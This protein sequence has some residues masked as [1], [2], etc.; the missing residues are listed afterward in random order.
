MAVRRLPPG[1][2]AVITLEQTKGGYSR[3]SPWLSKPKVVRDPVAAICDFIVDR[4]KAFIAE[5]SGLLCLHCAA[6]EIV[7][8]FSTI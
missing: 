3:T 4:T 2:P 7:A 5:D 6:L 8:G 1:G